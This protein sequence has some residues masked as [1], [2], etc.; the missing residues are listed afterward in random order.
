[1]LFSSKKSTLSTVALSI[2]TFSGGYANPVTEIEDANLTDIEVIQPQQNPVANPIV[3]FNQAQAERRIAVIAGLFV[4]AP[5]VLSYALSKGPV[6]H[7]M[8][9]AVIGGLLVPTLFITSITAIDFPYEDYY[10]QEGPIGK[11]TAFALNSLF[12]VLGI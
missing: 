2:F 8:I 4:G 7:R 5:A 11:G 6:K 10:D 3:P 1:M 12:N 9:D